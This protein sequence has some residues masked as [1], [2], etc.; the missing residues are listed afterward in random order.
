LEQADQTVD[1]ELRGGQP[2]AAKHMWLS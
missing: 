2:P 1:V